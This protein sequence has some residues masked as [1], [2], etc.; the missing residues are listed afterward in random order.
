MMHTNTALAWLLLL[1]LCGFPL[2]YFIGRIN[3]RVQRDPKGTRITRW[4]SLAVLLAMFVPLAMLA[5]AQMAGQPPAALQIHQVILRM[6]AIGLLLAAVSLALGTLVVIFSWAY[7][8]EEKGEGKFYALLLALVGTI[9]GLGCSQDLF[10]L[11]VWFEGMSLTAVILVTF[12]HN[13][14]GALE[15]GFKYLVQSVAGSVLIILGISLVLAQEGTLDMAVL[16]AVVPGVTSGMLAAGTLF[17]AGFGVKAAL[18]PMYTW[19]PDAHSQAPS[20][21]SAMLSGV[22][23]EAGLIAMLRALMPLAGFSDAWGPILLGFAAL[24]ML[25]GNLMALRQTQVKRL[26][27][28]SSAAQM[29]YILFGIGVSMT[30]GQPDG[31]MGGFFHIINHALMKGTAF[32]SAG[33][34]LYALYMAKGNHGPLVLDDLNGA[35]KRYPLVAFAFSVAV[36]GL[37]A[38]PPLAG[39]MSEW[40]ILLAGAKTTSPWMLG[41]VVFTALNSLLSLGYYA[42]MV[43]RLYRKQAGERVAVGE[44]IPASITIPVIVLTLGTVLLGVF[45]DLVSWLTGPAAALLT[46]AFNG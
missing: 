38:M 23:I 6:D 4:L 14:N 26:L 41:L 18:V 22:V 37:G 25:V 19:L 39:F 2:V 3:V 17:I 40:Q 29:G 42:P 32:L 30:Y 1:P 12:H 36:L 16:S 7:M 24:N 20:G 34:L 45:P 5:Q 46:A 10:N 15:A 27:A 9:I 11:W 21:V 35:A 44:K 13:Q 33:A 43:N 28:Y 31:A 8:A